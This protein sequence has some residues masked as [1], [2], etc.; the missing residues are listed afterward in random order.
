MKMINQNE[1]FESRLREVLRDALNWID[2]VPSDIVAG[3][4]AMPGFD[5]DYVEC[6][7]ASVTQ[8]KESQPSALMDEEWMKF[9]NHHPI[10][11]PENIRESIKELALSCGFVLQG[12]TN[13]E[14]DLRPYVYEFAEELVNACT[15]TYLAFIADI[16]KKA[17]KQE[18]RI[19][20]EA[21]QEAVA[22]CKAEESKLRAIGIHM[23]PAVAACLT[24]AEKIEKIGFK[25]DRAE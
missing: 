14:P 12:I 24:L 17:L 19:F 20:N 15:A 13:G 10:L 6:L 16:E 2:A 11:R 9:V 1:V 4:P 21:I 25:N 8:Q 22:M 18:Q 5:R 23:A 3:L 7:L